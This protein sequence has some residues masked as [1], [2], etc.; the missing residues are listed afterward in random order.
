MQIVVKT[1]SGMTTTID[2]EATDT[3]DSVKEKLQDNVGIPLEFQSLTFAGK[4]LK[5]GRALSDYNIQHDST[6]DLVLGK[7]TGLIRI[8]RWLGLKLCHFLLCG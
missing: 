5:H 4:Q 1:A 2:V 3:I 6:I 8:L 7:S